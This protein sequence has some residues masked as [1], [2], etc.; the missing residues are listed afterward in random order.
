[1][2]IGKEMNRESKEGRRQREWGDRKWK[3]EWREREGREV[4]TERELV[5]RMGIGKRRRFTESKRWREKCSWME[6]NMSRERDGSV[7]LGYSMAF[8]RAIQTLYFNCSISSLFTSPVANYLPSI[9]P[10]SHSLLSF[11][12][13]SPSSLLPSLPLSS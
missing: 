1:M 13:L 10:T 8:I 6:R 3:R 5:E 4:K 7:H 9:L 2:R 11:L 12:S